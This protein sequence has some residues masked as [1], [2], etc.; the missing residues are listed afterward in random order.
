MRGSVHAVSGGSEPER[1]PV[2]SRR[3]H[4]VIRF[5]LLVETTTEL[6]I[7]LLQIL[8]HIFLLTVIGVLNLISTISDALRVRLKE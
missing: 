4:T 1:F 5:L 7:V 2:R 8:Q 6:T 3:D